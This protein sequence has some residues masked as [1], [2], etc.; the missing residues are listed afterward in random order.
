MSD[1]LAFP[2]LTSG[3]DDDGNLKPTSDF[4]GVYAGLLEQWLSFDAE[5]ILPKGKSFA[6]P[7]LVK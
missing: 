1:H 2:G 5:R 7:T 4:R 6:R 3:L